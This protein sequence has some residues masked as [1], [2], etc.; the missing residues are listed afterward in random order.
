ME[1][2]NWLVTT[3][4]TNFSF[5]KIKTT[6]IRVVEI[7]AQALIISCNKSFFL[8]IKISGQ[9]FNNNLMYL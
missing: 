6:N 8:S 9:Y 1:E 3:L 5:I 4:N 2:N 7:D